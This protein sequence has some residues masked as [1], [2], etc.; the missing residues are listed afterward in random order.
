MFDSLGVGHSLNVFFNQTST[1]NWEWHALADGAEIGDPTST[2]AYSQTLDGQNVPLAFGSISF[3]DKGALMTESQSTITFAESPESPP[4]SFPFFNTDGTQTIG[5]DFG[6]SITTDGGKGLGGVT[7]FDA[8][9]S[10][11]GITQDGF[12]SGALAGITVELDGKI[13]GTFTNGERRT[14]AA[15]ALARFV[16]NDGLIRRDAG[17]WAESPNSGQALIGQAGTGGRGAIVGNNVEQSTTELAQEF[18]NLI[19][20]QRGF[21]ANSRTISTADDLLQ[22]A[23]NLKR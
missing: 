10:V 15:V 18:V 5:F 7:Q 23:V 2:P 12:G 6:E 9:S 22:E 20:F 3:N 1:G 13:I 17:H 4:R 16:N 19:T 14:L 21:Q 8:P 11:S